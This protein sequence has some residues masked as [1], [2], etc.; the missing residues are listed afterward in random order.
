MP[1]HTL[2]SIKKPIYNLKVIYFRGY[3]VVPFA[4]LSDY[5]ICLCFKLIPAIEE[6]C[7]QVY[8]TEFTEN[9]AFFSVSNIKNLVWLPSVCHLFYSHGKLLAVWST[10]KRLKG[11]S[12][13][14]W[15]LLCFLQF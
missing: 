2:K 12:R 3:F 5:I 14:M 9:D 6:V 10:G 13:L 1:Y 4:V 15:F 7:A 8:L 11:L